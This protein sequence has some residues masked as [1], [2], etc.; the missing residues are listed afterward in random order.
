MNMKDPDEFQPT[1]SK[2]LFAQSKAVGQLSVSPFEAWRVEPVCAV[3]LVAREHIVWL[4]RFHLHTR[5]KF[6]GQDLA[7]AL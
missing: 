2:V 7:C 6:L 1:G 5:L 4:L 3:V